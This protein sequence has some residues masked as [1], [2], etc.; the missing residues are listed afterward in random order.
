MK[1]HKSGMVPLPMTMGCL[2]TLLFLPLWAV[3]LPVNALR[4]A[5]SWLISG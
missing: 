5:L 1:L 3:I 4:N 2:T